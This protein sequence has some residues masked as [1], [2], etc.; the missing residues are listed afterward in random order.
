MW[1]NCRSSEKKIIKIP[2]EESTEKWKDRKTKKGRTEEAKCYS[3]KRR[4]ENRAWCRNSHTEE[5]GT[6]GALQA[7]E[8]NWV[9]GELATRNAGSE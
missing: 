8:L 4:G 5:R 9:P 3:G 1:L 2:G 6:W 7:K